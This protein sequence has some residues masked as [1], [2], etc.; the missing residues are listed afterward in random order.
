[1]KETLSLPV[2]DLRHLHYM[3]KTLGAFQRTPFSISPVWV[4]KA[5]SPGRNLFVAESNGTMLTG[6]TDFDEQRGADSTLSA[7]DIPSMLA[8]AIALDMP[9]GLDKALILDGKY[10]VP[11]ELVD[12]RMTLQLPGAN[13]RVLAF[14]AA[15]TS[16]KPELGNAPDHAVVIDAGDLAA[17]LVGVRHKSRLSSRTPGALLFT[18]SAGGLAVHNYSNQVITTSVVSTKNR[19]S[20]MEPQDFAVQPANRIVL[21]KILKQLAG[22]QT[23]ISTSLNT[24]QLILCGDHDIVI[25]KSDLDDG[26]PAPQPPTHPHGPELVRLVVSPGELSDCAQLVR[27]MQNDRSTRANRHDVSS[28]WTLHRNSIRVTLLGDSTKVDISVPTRTKV[29]PTRR[30]RLA[31]TLTPSSTIELL[32]RLAA[33]RASHELRFWD[34]RVQLTCHRSGIVLVVPATLRGRSLVGPAIPDQSIGKNA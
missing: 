14:P 30:T 18:T 7:A 24:K 6:L 20:V 32:A 33:P 19:T 9:E 10:V 13:R 25:L 27:S 15:L 22:R 26:R 12:G 3:A 8:R 29:W 28:R 1:M 2:S 31:F 21:A 16:L 5:S 23:E 11:A 4:S 17:A 34:D